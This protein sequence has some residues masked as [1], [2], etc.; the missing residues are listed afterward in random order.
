MARRGEGIYRRGT[1]WW[2][3]FLHQGERHYVRLGRNISRTVAGELAAVK[4]AAILKGEAGIGRKRKDLPF[5]KAAELF[6]AW[7]ETNKRRRTAAF[8][9]HCVSKLKKTFEGGT[10]GAITPFLV[11]KHKRTRAEEAGPVAA[12]RELATLKVLFNRC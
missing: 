11:E 8:Y 1:T 10:L 4:R 12:N 3:D 2:L 5:E 9:E 7:A 6:K